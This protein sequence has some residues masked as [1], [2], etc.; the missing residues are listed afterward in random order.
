MRRYST[1]PLSYCTNVHPGRTL[2]EVRRGLEQYT[3][4]VRERLGR[5]IAAGLW[6]ARSVVDEL[7]AEEGTLPRFAE[8]MHQQE[9]PCYTL[10]TFPYGD[11]HSERVKEN[12][13]LPDWASPERLQYTQLCAQALSVLLAEYDEG[14]LSSVPLGFAAFERPGMREACIENLRTLAGFLERLTEETGR[15][16]RLALEP[17]PLCILE[18]T[19]Q[20]VTFF[21]ALRD[22]AEGRAERERLERFV[23]VCYDVCHQ[24]V[25][26]ED[27]VA[28]IRTLQ[29]AGIRLN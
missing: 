13:Y 18:R 11:F 19:E 25:E 4:P 23:G 7:L 9:L 20:V 21:D 1:L 15:V 28:S 12:V 17:E 26:F 10:N 29:Q 14:S 8:W 5:P 16:I 6:L 24:A 3:L 27:V 22:A 2:Q